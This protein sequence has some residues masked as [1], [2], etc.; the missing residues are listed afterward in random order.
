MNS[1]VEF[2]YESFILI[3][4][5]SEISIYMQISNQLINAIQRGVLPFG[6][7]LPGTRAL[8]IILNVHRNTIVAA[9][10]ELFAQGWVESLP[11][12][13]TFV[14]G[15]NQEK[16]F[17]I[18]DFEKNNL[19]LY[20]KSTGFSFKTSN[21]LDN[22]FEYSDCEYIFNDGVP[23]IRLTQIDHHSRIYSSILKRKAHK[24]GQYNQDGS[25]FF[26]KNLSQF[27]NLSR[28]LPISKNN[29]LITRSTEMSIY[30]VSEILLAEG[31]IV[32]VGELSYFSVNMIFQKA[33]VNIQ[34][35]S[36]DEE[37][38]N[39]EEVR[40]ACKKQKIRMLYLTPHHHYPTTVTLSAKRRLEL[41]NLS[42]EFGFIILEDDYDYD[43]HYD[44]SPILP[45]ASADT[46]GMV[47]Y[48]GS[49]GKS[50]VPGFRTGFIVAP[51]N[52]MIEMRKY[53]GIIDRQGDV[54]ME[55]VL[56]EMIAEGEINRYLKKS[57]KIYQERRDYF[58]SLLEK[59]LGEYIDFQKP[60]GGLAVWMKWKIPVNLMQLSRNCAQNNLF[61]PKT[62]LYQNKDLTAMRMGFGNLN[63]TEMDKSI[64]ILSENIKLLS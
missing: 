34:S 40:A 27:L 41:L 39:V 12:K 52:L 46:N 33:G 25:E 32:L 17:Q 63:L 15:K 19:E 20:P 7:K 30:I 23:D 55:H 10:E 35:I 47:I 22:P 59:N 5:N 54:L 18:K 61:I 58:V 50:L 6:I 14:I 48:I 24:I 9:Y 53:L 8:S 44:K 38:I 16:P 37:G 64:E 45:L 31:D 62:L 21:I 51:E 36:I 49:F 1:P 60:S 28:G 13:G 2:P 3:N 26:K 57:L 11:N 43:F 56:G 29:L 4:R 42:N